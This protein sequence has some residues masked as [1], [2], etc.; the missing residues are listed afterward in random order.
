M[1]RCLRLW[2]DSKGEEMILIHNDGVSFHGESANCLLDRLIAREIEFNFSN[3]MNLNISK[4]ILY[5]VIGSSWKWNI[6]LRIN[7]GGEGLTGCGKNN[8]FNHDL[9]DTKKRYDANRRDERHCVEK[10]IA[11]DVINDGLERERE[12]EINYSNRTN[13]FPERGITFRDYFSTFRQ[14]GRENGL[15]D[16][17]SW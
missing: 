11:N 16:G 10:W 17:F 15:L 4:K 1:T 5:F 12:R 7:G 14:N 9:N 6:N 13:T 8:W 3:S 2:R